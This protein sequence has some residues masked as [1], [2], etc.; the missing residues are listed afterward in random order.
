MTVLLIGWLLVVAAVQVAAI[1]EL[2]QFFVRTEHGQ[3][4]DT[5]ALASNRIGAD[6]IGG[7]VNTVLNAISVV[8][9]LA[10]AG[11]VGFI[12][13]VRRRVV[14]AMVA[15]MLIAG[16][17]ITT[18]L[19]K[20]DITRPDLGVDEARAAAGN[21][22]PSGHTTIAAAV[23][24][25]LVLV[26]PP[27]VR[28]VGGLLGAGYAAIVGIAT[29]SAGWHRPS[30]AIAAFL[31]V[32]VWAALAG[33]VLLAAQRRSDR[34][35]VKESHRGAWITIGVLA[36]LLLV[37]AVVAL[38]VTDQVVR[39][40]TEELSQ[41]RLVAAYVGSAAGIAAAAGLMMTA[42]LATVHRVVPQRSS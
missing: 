25:A 13:L 1:I 32:G 4:L 19:L 30:D 41:R 11:T 29:L 37:G 26:L 33:L 40:P 10:A 20:R 34:V 23:A 8:A 17:T 5:I 42:V 21:S 2:W 38:Q 9:A 22:F 36:C 35:R 12:A 31:V 14:L 16:A 15:I 39:V 7:P 3:L 18:Q 27:R 6:K 24:V 28:G